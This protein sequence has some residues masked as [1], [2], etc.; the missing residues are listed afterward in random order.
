LVS[1][2]TTSEHGLCPP[3][4]GDQAVFD[5][6]LLGHWS[7]PALGPGQP[8]DGLR[9]N[10]D[11]TLI[12]FERH[13]DGSKAYLITTTDE[14]GK[15]SSDPPAVGHLVPIGN[16]R[17]LDVL[18]GDPKSNDEKRHALLKVSGD[19]DELAVQLMNPW[20]FSNHPT[21]LAHTSWAAS[22]RIPLVKGQLPEFSIQVP[23]L[24][25]QSP[26]LRKFLEDHVNDPEL[27][28]ADWTVKCRR[29]EARP[30]PDERTR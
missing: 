30:G 7:C 15:P 18:V 20:Y 28:P 25:A 8:K 27:W 14:A 23:T 17:F 2:C 12:R 1:G 29:S 21:A 3:D 13:K 5:P 10:P 11:G 4:G 6:A 16:A 22:G 19:K 26:E 9:I 24:T